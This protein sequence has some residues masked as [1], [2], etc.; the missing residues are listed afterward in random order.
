MIFEASAP[1]EI[2]FGSSTAP[3]ATSK[4]KFT[5]GLFLI[6][7][8]CVLLVFNSLLT[9][10]LF[11]E[12]EL[13]SPFIMTYIGMSLM[14]FLLPLHYYAAQKSSSPPHQESSTDTACIPSVGC[15]TSPSF[16]SLAHDMNKATTYT[17]FVDIAVQRSQK[18]VEDHTTRWNHRKH[19]LAALYITPAMFLAD[20][21]FNAALI[22]TSIASSTVLVSIQSIFV[23]A[24][25][26]VLRLDFYSVWKL[27]GILAGVAGTALTMLHDTTVVSSLETEETNDNFMVEDDT[28]TSQWWGDS[29]A[30]LAAMIYAI[31][32]I[33]VRL[34]CPENEELY[35]MQL[36]LGYIGA[37]ALVLMAPAAIW[38]LLITQQVQLT[39]ASLGM[40]LIKGLFDFCISDYLLFRS[41]ILTGPTVPTVG[42]GLSI[43][44]AFLLDFAFGNDD[45]FSWYSMVGALACLAGFFAVNLVPDP[46]TSCSCQDGGNDAVDTKD[47][48]EASLMDDTASVT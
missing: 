7:L 17:D 25:A 21:A 15:C 36:L 19:V 8:Q 32:T 33:Q 20:W 39:S 2:L 23:Y 35:S 13:E 28:A 16:D 4:W 45:V 31:Y 6:F 5:F 40:V 46:T 22:R 24:F 43:P 37:V 26:V 38:L 47:S 27:L 3:S 11:E 44:M 29:L 12:L 1:W 18:L 34:F 14:A 30:I 48:K 10:F 42:L 41:V 9:Q